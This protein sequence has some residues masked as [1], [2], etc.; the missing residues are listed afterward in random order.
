MGPPRGAGHVQNARAH[1]LPGAG[2]RDVQGLRAVAHPGQVFVQDENL[3]LPVTDAFE[4]AVAAMADMIVQGQEQEARV[5][6]DASHPVIVKGQEFVRPRTGGGQKGLQIGV[7]IHGLHGIF[8]R[9]I[10]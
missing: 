7:G 5:R 3:P 2:R 8:L 9:A 6:A 10:A 1:F 4:Q